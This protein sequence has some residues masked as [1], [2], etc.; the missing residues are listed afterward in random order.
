MADQ[1]SRR[2][3]IEDTWTR[4][5][6]RNWAKLDEAFAAL[7]LPPSTEGVERLAKEEFRN[8]R[9]ALFNTLSR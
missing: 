2:E 7:E 5:E 1:N 9:A 4:F 8:F 3:E 6:S